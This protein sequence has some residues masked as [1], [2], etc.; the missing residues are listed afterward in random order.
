[1]VEVRTRFDSRPIARARLNW[2]VIG[3]RISRTAVDQ[4]DSAAASHQH[5]SRLTK[6]S[7]CVVQA[8][9]LYGADMRSAAL[10]VSRAR[11]N[12][13]SKR[14]YFVSHPSRGHAC[15]RCAS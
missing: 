2:V 14:P 15:W 13:L 5:A 12:R 11:R 8:K 1:M 3:R 4:I 9:R 10:A 6:Q 7:K